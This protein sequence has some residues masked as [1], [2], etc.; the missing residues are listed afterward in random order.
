M[1]KDFCNCQP[2]IQSIYRQLK[3]ERVTFENSAKCLIN[4]AGKQSDLP[5]TDVAEMMSS[6]GDSRW[7]TEDIESEGIF[8]RKTAM[9]YNDTREDLDEIL[10]KIHRSLDRVQVSTISR[11]KLPETGLQVTAINLIPSSPRKQRNLRSTRPRD[12]GSVYC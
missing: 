7:T 2:L 4:A 10:H 12:N 3:R 11:P 8:S 5:L 6:P 9:L 1:I